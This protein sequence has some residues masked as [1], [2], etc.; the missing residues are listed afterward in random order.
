MSDY[1]SEATDNVT[2]T[3]PETS[4]ANGDA[5]GIFPPVVNDDSG[6][7][8]GGSGPI[9]SSTAFLVILGIVVMAGIGYAVF[10]LFLKPGTVQLPTQNVVAAPV[11]PTLDPVAVTDPSAFLA[12]MPTTVGAYVLTEYTVQSDANPEGAAEGSELP[13]GVA[14]IDTLTYSDGSSEI[15]VTSFQHYNISEAQSTFEELNV[16]GSDL[17]P[18][19]VAGEEVGNQ[20]TMAS[21]AGPTV[22]WINN[23]AVFTATGDDDSV[24]TFVGGFG[25]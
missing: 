4:P 14:E 20:V 21:D 6:A 13:E 11:E 8:D 23:T 5:D 25:F 16:D 2:V 22:L 15:V 3:D 19:V 17:Q 7:R 24:V 18:V 10:A 1:D 12:A 9:W